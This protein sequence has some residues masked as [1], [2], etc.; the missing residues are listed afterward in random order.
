MIPPRWR[1]MLVFILA[2]ALSYLDRQILSALAPT[3]KG[4]YGL[5]DRQF[6]WVVST[7]SFVYALAAPLAGLFIDRAGLTVGICSSVGLWSMAG[8]ATGFTGGLNSLLACRAWLGLAESGN[9]P[10]SAKTIAMYL[11]P[12]ERALGSGVGQLGITIGMVCSPLM[13]SYVAGLYG[14]RAA[15]LVAGLLGFLW[16][17]LWLSATRGVPTNALSPEAGSSWDL[18]TDRR[19]WG[20]VIANM[21]AMTTYSLW[22]NWTTIF[23]VNTYGLSQDQ[24]NY[25]VAWIP[26]I[27][28]A[29]GGLTGGALSLRFQRGGLSLIDARFRASLIGSS[30]LLLTALTPYL[31]NSLLAAL[32]IGWSFFWTVAYSANLYALPID[33]FGPERAGQAVAALTMGFGLLQT[34]L[35]PWIGSLV[36]ESGFGRVCLI[37]AVMP[38]LSYQVLRLTRRPA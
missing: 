37:I 14:W 24:A 1:V 36:K 27:F 16:I 17:P 8:I 32:A 13:A 20:L 31:P 4:E 18:V 35:S 21:L 12:R 34:V 29:L 28:A 33:Y 19:L 11:E 25:R 26:P 22:S 15:F 9:F 10:A 23:F 7:F 3:I 2:S 5:D 6:G 30:A 38:L